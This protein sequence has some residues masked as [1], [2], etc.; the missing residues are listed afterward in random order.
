[1]E[2]YWNTK[3]DDSFKVDLFSFELLNTKYNLYS[4]NGV[5]SAFKADTGS[6]VLSEVLLEKISDDSVCDGLDIGC[7]NALISI[8]LAE[9]IDGYKGDMCDISPRAIELSKM[10]IKM[11][12]FQD[13][14]SVFESNKFENVKSRYDYIFTNPPIRTGKENIFS[15]YD[16]SPSFL[17]DGGSF[18]VVIRKNHGAK[19]HQKKLQEVYGNCDIVKKSKGYY[20]LSSRK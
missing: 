4:S 20:I 10:N 3:L 17:N 19:S 16:D 14:L 9:K 12:N 2:H 18:F 1:M 7:G 15:I 11:Y 6:L 13:R 5:F 8:I